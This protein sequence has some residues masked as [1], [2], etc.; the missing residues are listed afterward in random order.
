MVRQR[1]QLFNLRGGDRDELVKYMLA[2][3]SGLRAGDQILAQTT[4][5]FWQKQNFG[6]NGRLLT[7]L[8]MAAIHQIHVR[9]VL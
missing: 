9:W 7:M 8:K 6:A 1:S 3:F 2:A 5:I 4:P